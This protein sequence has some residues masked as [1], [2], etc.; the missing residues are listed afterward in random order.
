MSKP[1][2]HDPQSSMQGA[3]WFMFTVKI[4]PL[5]Q[6]PVDRIYMAR[7]VSTREHQ[8]SKKGKD[9]GSI[10]CLDSTTGLQINLGKRCDH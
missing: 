2:R 8:F 1:R 10:C 9:V 4:L 5:E 7:D 6:W 3:K